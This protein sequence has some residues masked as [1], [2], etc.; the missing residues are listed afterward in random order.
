LALSA[1]AVPLP[2]A[3]AKCNDLSSLSTDERK[4]LMCCSASFTTSSSTLVMTLDIM[5]DKDDMTQ[6]ISTTRGFV[7][8]RE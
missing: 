5:A 6:Y 3:A 4:I 1:L 2:A 8:E 7:A